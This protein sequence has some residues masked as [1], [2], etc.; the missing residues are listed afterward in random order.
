MSGYPRPEVLYKV[1]V[2][3]V[4]SPLSKPTNTLK[5]A[6]ILATDALEER[7]DGPVLVGWARKVVRKPSAGEASRHL[8][9]H[10]KRATNGRD[11]GTL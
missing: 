2:S 10:L 6:R 4:R 1:Y 8:R 11:E 5:E 9:V 7:R 3:K